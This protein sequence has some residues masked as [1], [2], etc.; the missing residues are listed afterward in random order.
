MF[1]QIPDTYYS[2]LSKFLE[3]NNQKAMAFDI[4]PDLDHKFDL[5]I[6]LSRI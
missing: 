4:T 2:K 6:S 5:A 1:G 3:S